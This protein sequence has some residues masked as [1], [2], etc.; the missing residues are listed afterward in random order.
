MMIY[1]DVIWPSLSDLLVDDGGIAE[2]PQ[3]RGDLPSQVSKNHDC[4]LNGSFE[5]AQEMG[6]KDPLRAG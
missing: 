5:D 6:A 1:W 4:G 3:R 2:G